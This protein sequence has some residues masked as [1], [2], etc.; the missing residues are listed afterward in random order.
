KQVDR[1]LSNQNIDVWDAFARWV[2]HLIGARKEI[3]VG[4]VSPNRRKFRRPE[5]GPAAPAAGRNFPYFR[6]NPERWNAVT[7]IQAGS[8]SL[9]RAP[10]AIENRKVPARGAFGGAKSGLTEFSAVRAYTPK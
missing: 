3:V 9:D 7:G 10:P 2:P 4:G 5:S 1:L 6:S 8:K